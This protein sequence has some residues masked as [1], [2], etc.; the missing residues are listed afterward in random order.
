M[1]HAA[2]CICSHRSHNDG[3]EDTTTMDLTLKR[4]A[5]FPGYLNENDLKKRHCVM[6]GVHCWYNTTQKGDA[7]MITTYNKRICNSCTAAI[8]KFDDDALIKWCVGSRSFRS[9]QAFGDSPQAKTC[10]HCR[11]RQRDNTKAYRN[12]KRIK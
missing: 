11:N 2:R 9:L 3:N 10:L 1:N 7:S 4:V 6:C 8:W 12:R 5:N